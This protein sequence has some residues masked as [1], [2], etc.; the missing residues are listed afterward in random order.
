VRF[1]D[2]M[3]APPA[4]FDNTWI[5]EVVDLASGMPVDDAVLEVDPRMPDH[6][7]GTSIQCE[8]TAMAAP[9]QFQLDPVNLF[10]PGLWEVELDFTLA[11]ETTDRVVFKFC[12][13]P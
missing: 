7:H 4:R 8:V 2:A 1:V 13:D 3:P 12:V 11:D 6:N 9:G 10:M 5:I